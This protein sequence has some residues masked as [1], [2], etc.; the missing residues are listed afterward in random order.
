MKS[1][2]AIRN[3]SYELTKP[4]IGSRQKEVLDLLK[5]HSP[6][7]AWQISDI[8]GRP[9]YQVRPRLTELERLGLIRSGGTLF[10]ERTQRKESLYWFIDTDK[11][12]QLSLI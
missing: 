10:Q 8:L 1:S 9:V 7:T 12:G 2:L 4:E 5:T 6:Y 3:E 11:S